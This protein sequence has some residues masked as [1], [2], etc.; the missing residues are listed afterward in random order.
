MSL[1]V[2][3]ELLCFIDEHNEEKSITCVMQTHF[4]LAVNTSKKWNSQEA[5]LLA[6]TSSLQ[7][8]KSNENIT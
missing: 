7:G 1:A 2:S 5:S 3:F 4:T 8:E 6:W